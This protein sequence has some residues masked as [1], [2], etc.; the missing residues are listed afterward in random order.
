MATTYREMLE[1]FASGE[2]NMD[3]FITDL[4]RKA[5][6]AD[7]VKN[8]LGL[9]GNSEETA[10]E[11]M[12]AVAPLADEFEELNPLDPDQLVAFRKKLDAALKPIVAA[13]ARAQMRRHFGLAG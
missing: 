6:L 11:L 4:A 5:S 12:A 10:R 8:T 1:A 9:A 13:T 2:T 7:M 3:A